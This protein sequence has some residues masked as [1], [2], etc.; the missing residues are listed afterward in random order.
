MQTNHNIVVIFDGV[1]YTAEAQAR[2]GADDF[3]RY[4]ARRNMFTGTLETREAKAR[5]L[6]EL[7][8][9]KCKEAGIIPQPITLKASIAD[10]VAKAPKKTEKQEVP[11]PKN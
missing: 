7:C 4:A 9:A 10:T 8:V 2:Y 11:A 6:H 3:V 5:K 1:T